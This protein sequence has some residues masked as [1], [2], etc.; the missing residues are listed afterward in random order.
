MIQTTKLFRLTGEWYLGQSVAG[1]T[2]AHVA[3]CCGVCVRA[4]HVC[5]GD[6]LGATVGMN[7]SPWPHGTASP[8][9]YA[10]RLSMP[11]RRVPEHFVVTY[12]P[13]QTRLK[14]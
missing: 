13:E 4:C 6:P 5:G 10:E 12:N 2:A 11:D 8:W 1:A 7:L 14:A 3:C 9:P